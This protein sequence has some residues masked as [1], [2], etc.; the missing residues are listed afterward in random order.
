MT[1]LTASN[2]QKIL[3]LSRE[4]GQSFQELVQ[5]FAMS[6]FLYRL[7]KSGTSDRFILK[8]ALL[9]RAR[10]TPSA[11]IFRRSRVITR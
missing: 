4:T 5:Y 11:D 7:A 1:D 10:E 8:G 6:R 3:N 2:R 9:L